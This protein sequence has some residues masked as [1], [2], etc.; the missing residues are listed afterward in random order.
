MSPQPTLN[1]SFSLLKNQWAVSGCL[2]NTEVY[3][4]EELETGRQRYQDNTHLQSR[5]STPKTQVF[6]SHLV[7]QGQACALA[8]YKGLPSSS[9]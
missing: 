4:C 3:F 1:L 2:L 5:A 7:R 9:L 8:L 6:Q